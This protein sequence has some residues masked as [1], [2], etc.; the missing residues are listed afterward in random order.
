MILRAKS[1]RV[2][3]EKNGK[4]TFDLIGGDLPPEWLCKLFP[5]SKSQKSRFQCVGGE[6]TFDGKPLPTD[7]ELTEADFPSR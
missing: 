3:G 5:E 4:P 7:R 2:A 1:V 6:V